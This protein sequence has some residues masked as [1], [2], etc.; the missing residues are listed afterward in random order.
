MV[1]PCVAAAAAAAAAAC[2]FRG[3]RP[4]RPQCCQNRV[5]TKTI[6]RGA[7]R[8]RNVIQVRKSCDLQ[9]LPPSLSPAIEYTPTYHWCTTRTMRA[10]AAAAAAAIAAVTTGLL[11]MRDTALRIFEV[12][13]VGE[14]SSKMS[15]STI[16][17]C[18]VTTRMPNGQ[19]STG[20][21]PRLRSLA[22]SRTAIPTNYPGVV[23]RRPQ[24]VGA[25]ARG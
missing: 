21:N 17:A 23:G 7:N 2:V 19:P 24:A 15:P 6:I 1:S 9:P 13:G 3:C 10:A 20:A 14:L 25:A 11:N 4:Y 16:T 5:N 12:G 22:S 8:A 18:G